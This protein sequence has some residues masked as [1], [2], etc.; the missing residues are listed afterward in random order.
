M[1]NKTNYIK[2]IAKI[3]LQD[4]KTKVV[5]F[6]KKKLVGCKGTLIDKTGKEYQIF[7]QEP[8]QYYVDLRLNNPKLGIVVKGVFWALCNYESDLT[9]VTNKFKGINAIELAKSFLKGAR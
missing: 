4:K 1:E 6:E 9:K 8:L 3:P 2:R 7:L 5:R